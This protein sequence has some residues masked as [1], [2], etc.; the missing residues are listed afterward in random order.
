MGTEMTTHFDETRRQFKAQMTELRL[1]LESKDSLLMSM[2]QEHN[3]A[4][5]QLI[6]RGELTELK[7]QNNACISVWT[8]EH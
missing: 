7:A 5:G 2:Q 1:R 3:D 6:G 8:L 4:R